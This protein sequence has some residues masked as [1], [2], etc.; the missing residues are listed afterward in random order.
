MPNHGGI[1]D[2]HPMN[3]EEFTHE[4]FNLSEK[5]FVVAFNPLRNPELMCR[6]GFAKIRQ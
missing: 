4:N 3:I 6:T 1:G 2:A 5:G